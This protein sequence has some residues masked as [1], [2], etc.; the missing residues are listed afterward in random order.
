MSN[1][2]PIWHQIWQTGGW[3]LYTEKEFPYTLEVL[4]YIRICH[5]ICGIRNSMW[6]YMT[7]HDRSWGVW[8]LNGV[9]WDKNSKQEIS[10]AATRR[11]CPDSPVFQLQLP[12]QLTQQWFERWP[13][14]TK[15][16]F[17]AKGTYLQVPISKL[18]KLEWLGGG[19]LSVEK[20]FTLS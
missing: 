2:L 3:M 8:H 10:C 12:I 15:P 17:P 9:N 18:L 14:H 13:Y 16:Q 4:T 11:T 5:K 19:G 20:S 6:M 1:S 7:V